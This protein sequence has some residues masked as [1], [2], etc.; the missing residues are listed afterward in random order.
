MTLNAVSA[1]KKGRKIK[2]NVFFTIFPPAKSLESR[3]SYLHKRPFLLPIAWICR[4]FAYLKESLTE[5]KSAAKE[6]IRTG[7]RRVELLRQ[8]DIID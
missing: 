8:Y 4:I 1:D 3:F 2:G 6:V 7:E 5:P